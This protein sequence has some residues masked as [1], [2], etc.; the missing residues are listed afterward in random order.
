MKS[1]KQKQEEVEYLRKE[2]SEVQNLI[3][4]KFQGLNVAGDTEL[5]NKVR[6]TDSKYRVIKNRL[7]NVAAEGTRVEPLVSSFDGP[8]AIAYNSGEPVSLAKVRSDYAKANPV[9]EFKAGMVEGRV[10]ELS[11]LAE[12]AAMP[13]HDE[14][15]AQL[16][17]LI[18]A[19]AQ[20]IALGVN[21]VMRNLAVALG[22]ALEQ[23]KFGTDP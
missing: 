18:N 10:V 7:A 20:R 12:I 6:E 14:L 23:G 8:T 15:I 21:A 19:P 13:T 17:Y 11:M 5:R 16:M 3:V 22:Q 4:V 9:F 1:K 2:F